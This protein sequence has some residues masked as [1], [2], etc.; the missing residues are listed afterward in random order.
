MRRGLSKL[1]A[2]PWLIEPPSLL[3]AGGMLSRMEC[4]VDDGI[5]PAPSKLGG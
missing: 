4:F 3:G 1:S 2:G 5:A